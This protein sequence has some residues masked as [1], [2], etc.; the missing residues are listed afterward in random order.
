MTPD[1]F[2]G[3]IGSARGNHLVLASAPL[4][5]QIKYTA[6]Q[7]ITMNYRT[8]NLNQ[9]TFASTNAQTVAQR[10]QLLQELVP[11]TGSLAELCCGDCYRQWHAYTE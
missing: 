1:T 4:P 3:W 8:P 7:R 9:H 10:L 5:C 6:R 2:P 11:Q